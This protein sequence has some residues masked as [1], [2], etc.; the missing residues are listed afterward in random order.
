MKSGGF[1]ER[2][3]LGDQPQAAANKDY[4]GFQDFRWISEF[5]VDFRQVHS[6]ICNEIRSEILMKSTVKS[7]MKYTV[8]SAAKS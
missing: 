8:K 7:A 5:L 2:P 6:K 1:K 4:N 3:I